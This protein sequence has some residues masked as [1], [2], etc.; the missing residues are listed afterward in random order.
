MYYSYYITANVLDIS[1]NLL[2]SSTLAVIES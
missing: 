1:D 2:I